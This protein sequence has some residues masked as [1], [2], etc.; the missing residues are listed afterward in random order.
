[1]SFE[2]TARRLA[3]HQCC[4]VLLR[5]YVAGA[6]PLKSTATAAFLNIFRYSGR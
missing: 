1:M 5:L 3:S 2:R 4:V 6:W